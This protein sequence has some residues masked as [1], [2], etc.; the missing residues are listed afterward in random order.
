[1]LNIISKELKE[2]VRDGRIKI[3]AIITVFLLIIAASTGVSQYKTESHQHNDSVSKERLIWETQKSK[4]PH[5][6]AHYGTYIFKP[7]LALS[8]LDGGVTNFTGNSIFVEAHNKNEASFSDATDQTSLSRFGTLSINF[9]LIYLFPLIIIL[10]GYNS[11]TKERENQTYILLKSQSIHPLKLVLG[12]WIAT[13]IPVLTL[14]IIIFFIIGSILSNIPDLEGFKWINLFT[15]LLVYI[16]Y[17]LITTTLTILISMWSKSSG[18]SLFFSLLIW[19]LFSFITPKIAT[20]IANEKNPYPSK[21]EFDTKIS[22]D[23]KEGLDGHNPW[24]KA[25]KNLEYETLKK[26]AVDSIHKLPFNYVGYRMQKGE[27][28]EAKIYE[29]N[30]AALKK[31]AMNQNDSYKK[32]SFISPFIALRFISMDLANSSDNLHW[33]FSEEV[34]KYR[35]QKQQFLNYDIKDNSKFGEKGYKM[36]TKK[37]KNLPKFKFQP[38]ELLELLKN[39]MQNLLFLILWLV[40]PFIG[41]LITS[42]KI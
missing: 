35:I 5:S 18:A 22:N 40:L 41:L 38:P 14:T 28:H 32:L 34:E 21:F 31:I 23:K 27:E 8:L 1:M 33:K 25:A 20:N 29:Q 24:N 2:L 26:Y 9:I 17:Y 11:Y 3:T 16:S 36:N 37:F 19:V 30:Y 42:K 7:K 4:N 13:L 15:I 39:N 12:K 6:A 10:I